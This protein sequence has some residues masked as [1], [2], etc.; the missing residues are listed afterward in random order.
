MDGYPVEAGRSIGEKLWEELD[1]IVERLMSGE[2]AD[3]GRDPGR[4]EGVAFCIA[5]LTHS[6]GE[7]NIE[8]VRA[9]AMERWETAQAE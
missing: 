3:D 6:P 8:R 9:E 1:R 2:E 5:V 7:A 4:A